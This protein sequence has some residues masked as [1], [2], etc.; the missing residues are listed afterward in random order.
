MNAYVGSKIDKK[1][2]MHPPEGVEHQP[3]QVCEILRS[4]YGL[5]QSGRLWN[6]KI[7]AYIKKIGFKPTTA[8]PSVFI[9]E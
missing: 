8:D 3:G 2:L 5:K 6:L 9:N 7:T 1:I 4:L